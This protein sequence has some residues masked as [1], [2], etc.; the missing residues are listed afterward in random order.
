MSKNVLLIFFLY[1]FSIVL[2]GQPHWTVASEREVNY[3]QK[4]FFTG[5]AQGNLRQNETVEDA[6]NRLMREAQG[7]LSESIRINV[8]S[9]TASRTVSTTVNNRDRFD[10]VFESDVQT[11]SDIEIVGIRSEPPYYDKATG[12]VYAFA[13]VSRQE[14][15]NYYKSNLAM[16]LTQV[17]GLL[18]TAKNLEEAGQK[19]KARQQCDAT[20]PLLSRI[21]SVQDLLT[22]INPGIS[23]ED[24]QQAKTET[25]HNQIVKMR[26]LLA[27]AVLVYVE[28]KEF[29]FDEQVNIVANQLK[30]EL[31]KSGCSFV[32]D[33]KKADFKLNIKVSTRH[34]NTN[35]NFVFCIADT[36]VELYDIRKQ[37]IVY[38][39]LIS[40]RSG[41]TSQE[42]AARRAMTDVVKKVS[43]SLKPW[44]EN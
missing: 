20:L 36:Q 15:S 35:N 38:S 21:R 26:A 37:K 29:L 14:L 25:I 18:Q 7:L 8:R 1:T 28:S 40:Q 24:L 9:Q 44:V 11:A 19:V 4:T 34:A 30:A 27:Q 17:E 33:A 43:E 2:Y 39:D 6:K 13:H 41:D 16:N 12:I 31:A 32:D 22:A 23:S 10:A 3:P 5:Y 42:R